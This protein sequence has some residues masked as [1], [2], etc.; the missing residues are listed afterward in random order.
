VVYLRERLRAVRRDLDGTDPRT[1]ARKLAAYHAWMASPL[2]PSTARGP[3]HLLP[4]YLQ[5][6]LSK[7][8][9]RNIALFCLRAHT[10]R[11]KT[12]CWQNHNRYCEK[13]DLHD[14]QDEKHVILNAL[15]WK[16]A[17]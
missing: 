17:V 15:A 11:A 13:C 7:H 6:E 9:L 4:R 3:P 2:K 1:H 16:C 10:L 5:L 14:V 8:V 12:G